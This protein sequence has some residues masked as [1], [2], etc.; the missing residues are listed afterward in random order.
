MKRVIIFFL[1]SAFTV[2]AVNAEKNHKAD[3]SASQ[4]T[5]TGKKVTGQHTGT[6]LLKEGWITVDGN[7][8]TGGEFIIDM[9]S[10]K[11]TDLKDEKTRG[12]L[13]GHLKSDDFF[14]V[15]KFPLSNLVITG[16]ELKD[17][18][19]TVKGNLTIKGKTNPIE[20]TTVKTKEGDAVVYTALITVDRS[21]FDV[22]YGSGKFFANLGD[23]V[24]YDEFTLDVKLVLQK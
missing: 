3:V 1:L 6:I 20:F 2:L 7:A 19:I 16:S 13:E 8:I 14:G 9:S 22:R 17:G 21:E 15:E 24:I 4:I 10:I 11:D 5:W 12:M 23:K 18:K